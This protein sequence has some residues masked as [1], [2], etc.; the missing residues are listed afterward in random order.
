MVNITFT[1]PDDKF[2]EYMTGLASFFEWNGEGN[3][4]DFVRQKTIESFKAWFKLAQRKAHIE[5]FTYDDI[6]IT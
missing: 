5:S 6:D 1:I 4:N 2:E 3:R